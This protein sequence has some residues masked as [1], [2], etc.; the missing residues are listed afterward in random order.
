VARIRANLAA[1]SALR[2][3]QRDGRP[4]TAAEQAVLARWSGWGAVPEVFDTARQEF[5]WAREE[6][7]GLLAPEETATA[8]R[9]T[10]NAHHTDAELVQATWAGA[11]TRPHRFGVGLG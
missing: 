10:L 4:A 5:A 2:G 6:L 9:N 11:A 1:L 3:I 7:A 8:A